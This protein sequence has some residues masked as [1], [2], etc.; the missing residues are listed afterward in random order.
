VRN[1][2]AVEHRLEFVIK[3]AAWIIHDPRQRMSMRRSRRWNPFRR[4]SFDLGGKDKG[5]DYTV[6][7]ELLRQ[8]VKR[9]T[10]LGGGGED[11][12]A[13][14]GAAEIE[15]AET[16][17]NACGAR[18]NGGGGRCGAAGSGLR[19]LRSV[20]SYE[21]RGRVLK[22]WCIRWDGAVS[23]GRGLSK[24]PA[25]PIKYIGPSLRSG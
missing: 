1:F 14:S 11:R 16:L 20:S 10:R 5:S 24:A 3:I 21:H 18:V 7:N 17:E 6:L 12:R 15:H 9:S 22:K 19:Q 2:K 13:D 4:I 8:R 23:V 25:V